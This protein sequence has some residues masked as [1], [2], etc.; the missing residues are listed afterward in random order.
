MTSTPGEG[1]GKP[2]RV[3]LKRNKGWRMPENTVKVAR[4]TKW[5]NPLRIGE[6]ILACGEPIVN[7]MGPLVQRAATPEDAVRYYRNLAGKLGASAFEALRGKNLACYCPLDQ[8]CH[9]D[10]LLEIANP[11]PRGKG[12]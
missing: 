2:V 7:G 3:Q 5:G 1:A 8:P 12:P 9:A 10:V 4:P 11:Q 6:V